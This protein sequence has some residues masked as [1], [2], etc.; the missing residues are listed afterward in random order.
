MFNPLKS[1]Q[2]RFHNYCIFTLDISTLLYVHIRRF[3][4]AYNK[5][6]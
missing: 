6:T 3:N 2:D 5:F 1:V 4:S